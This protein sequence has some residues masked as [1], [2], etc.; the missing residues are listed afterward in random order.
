MIDFTGGAE[1]VELVESDAVVA[2]TLCT[3]GE[4]WRVEFR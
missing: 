2:E 3:V 4:R 1:V